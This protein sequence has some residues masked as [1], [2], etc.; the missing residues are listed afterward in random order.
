M[1]TLSRSRRTKSA[2]CVGPNIKTCQPATIDPSILGKGKVSLPGNVEVSFLNLIG[3]SSYSYGNNN[4]STLIVNYNPTT[5]GMNG[6]AMSAD[7]R[8]YVIENCGSQG[9]V[10]KEID[11][12]KFVDDE[13]YG[14]EGVKGNSR[15]RSNTQ[16]V[17]DTTT[18]VTYSV[19]IY[20]TKKFA[21]ATSD[22]QGFTDLVIAETN[23]G[24]IN[25]KV[26]LRIKKHCTEQ[27]SI[28]DGKSSAVTL[29]SLAGLKPTLAEIRKSADVAVL[30]V[31]SFDVS[32]ACGRAKLFA[33]DAGTP[34][35]G[36]TISVVA[37]SCAL[38]YYSFGHEIGHNIGLY[39]D[40]G[41]SRN[42]KYTYGHGGFIAKG[43]GSTGYRTTMSYS[44]TG[45]TTRVNYYSNPSV[46]HPV[47]GTVTGVAGKADNARLLTEQRFKLAAMGSES[48]VCGGGKHN[49]CFE[50][51]GG[52]TKKI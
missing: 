10:F 12:S 15:E 42:P 17:A 43:R 18:I 14:N 40:E 13:D 7:S 44:Q 4:G 3:N 47:T 1:V 36:K 23:Q 16:T 6:H 27:V 30:L 28:A 45:Y 33:I 29:N 25:S 35:F 34:D 41:T 48:I 38:G 39:H 26:P 46:K 19:Q 9:H 11:I 24:Y 50:Q 2:C 37:K 20:F 51:I 21:D 32:Y 49:F 31:N 8:S 5:G 22:I 52:T